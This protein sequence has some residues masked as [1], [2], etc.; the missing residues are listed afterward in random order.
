M[1]FFFLKKSNRTR[2]IL[3]VQAPDIY[4]RR[5]KK[6]RQAHTQNGTPERND[7]EGA[8]QHPKKHYELRREV[9]EG[10]DE[11]G[12]DDSTV[13]WG[14]LGWTVQHHRR[15]CW[16]TT[17]WIKGGRSVGTEHRLSRKARRLRRTALHIF[18]RQVG[19]AGTVQFCVVLGWTEIPEICCCA[20]LCGPVVPLWMLLVYGGSGVVLLVAVLRRQHF[21]GSPVHLQG[22]DS[23]DVPGEF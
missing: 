7:Q 10:K 14:E 6:R 18:L 12:K 4:K 15:F 17:R 19:G 13:S 20:G 16:T 8:A 3:F 1:L 22:C 2:L 23:A 5:G 11:G 9:E 21:L